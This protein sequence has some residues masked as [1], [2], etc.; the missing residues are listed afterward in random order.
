MKLLQRFYTNTRSRLKRR[1]SYLLIFLNGF[2]LASL[3]YFYMEDNYEWKVFN[4]LVSH[5]KSTASQKTNTDKTEE[6]IRTSLSLTNFLGQ[7]RMKIFEGQDLESIKSELIHPVSF[8]LMTGKGA[9]G[10][11]SYI[12]SRLLSELKIPNRIAQMKVDGNYGGHN[13]VEAKTDKGWVVLDPL[14][15][16]YFT[17]QDGNMASF[18]DVQKDWGYYKMQIP[19]GYDEKYNYADVRY[20]NWSKVPVIMPAMKKVLQWTIGKEETETFSLRTHMLR[21]YLLLFNVALVLYI[22]TFFATVRKFIKRK[23]LARSFKTDLSFIS[24]TNAPVAVM[25]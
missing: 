12:L 22:L 9:C 24:R 1:S 8:D 21:K 11:Y 5:I 14:Y 10:S 18:A 3:G 2:L 25:Q 13:I 17:R 7:N 6:L 16:L 19:Q 15:N 4:S 20:T 23:R